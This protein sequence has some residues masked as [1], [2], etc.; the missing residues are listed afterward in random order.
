MRIVR[1]GL[2]SLLQRLQ[3]QDPPF[4][5][6]NLA[7][8]AA[9]LR[10]IPACIANRRML[11]DRRDDMARRQI[12]ARC[13]H[14]DSP[15]VGLR[16]AGRKIDLRRPGTDQIRHLFPRQLNSPP[17][18]CSHRMIPH[19][20]TVLLQQIRLHGLKGRLFQL[21]RRSVVQIDHRLLLSV[22]LP[23]AQ[24]FSPVCQPDSHFDIFP[25]CL[26]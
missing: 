16:P 15:V 8:L 22:I 11:D 21:R 9:Q 1:R 14:L 18:L 3:I 7:H 17:A 5:H 13:R 26:I 4:I 2:C 24:P 6:R 12:A 25:I 19:G 20:I 10:Q 23:L